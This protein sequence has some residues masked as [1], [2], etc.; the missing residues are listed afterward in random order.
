MR[1]FMCNICWDIGGEYWEGL[2]IIISIVI[3]NV[4][5][6]SVSRDSHVSSP[7]KNITL[8]QL[9]QADFRQIQAPEGTKS[10]RNAVVHDV[11]P[12]V[13][14]K[15]TTISFVFSLSTCARKTGLLPTPSLLL[16]SNIKRCEAFNVIIQN[17]S[18][19]LERVPSSTEEWFRFVCSSLI[20]RQ[21]GCTAGNFC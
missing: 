18:S 6:N 1:V 3:I 17:Y 21:V 10:R 9:L 14:P 15:G 7:T 8:I 12:L 11:C 20:H 2:E 19:L 13:L 16:C 5:Q 4:H